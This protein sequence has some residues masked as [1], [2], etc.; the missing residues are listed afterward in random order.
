MN[1]AQRNVLVRVEKAFG[2]VPNVL[3]EMSRVPALVDIYLDNTAAL[4]TGSFTPLEQQVIQEAVSVYNECSYCTTVGGAL[5][6]QLGLADDEIHA[7]ATH[8]LPQDARLAN[9][10]TAV[11][12]VMDKRGWL[13]DADLA[14][15][16]AKGIER[17]QIYEIIGFV[18]LKL[19]A[20]MINHINKT[21]LDEVFRQTEAA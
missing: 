21:E 7:I 13:D 19:V 4:A 16:K 3:K 15:L 10:V 9:I 18:A 2:F 14:E 17:E 20:N 11:W 8:K 6:K 5:C 12:R 1:N